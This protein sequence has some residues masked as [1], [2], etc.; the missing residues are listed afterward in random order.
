MLEIVE[1][2]ECPE[3]SSFGVGGAGYYEHRGISITFNDGTVY[4]GFYRFNPA[5]YGRF[6]VVTDRSRYH[7][8]DGRILKHHIQ[9][10]DR[11]A[12]V[13]KEILGRLK[14]LEGTTFRNINE[15]KKAIRRAGE[16]T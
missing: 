15:A 9:Y 13:F 2:K 12:L 5:S 6:Q 3:I 10:R 14:T 8:L 1:V 4:E 16:H 7:G 11:V